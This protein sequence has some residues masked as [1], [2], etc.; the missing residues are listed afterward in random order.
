MNDACARARGWLAQWAD[1]ELAP[2]EASWIEMHW[3]EC[4]GCRGERDRFQQVDE[5]LLAFG[6]RIGESADGTADR[7]RFLERIDEVESRGWKP[8]AWT[9]AMAA[10][11]AAA[12]VLAIW[13]PQPAERPTAPGRN[14]FVAV[15]Y[16]APIT[17]YERRTVV[18]MQIPVANLLADGYL[19]TADPSSVVQADVL[20]GED[21][22]VHAVRLAGN[23]ILKGGGE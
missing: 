1:G 16:L 22:W 19:L 23:Q 14:G 9:P 15:P 7:V 3:A 11:L 13:L 17:S 5:S 8:L 4:D 10:L 2:A 20:L 12:T 18:S 6:E 21:G